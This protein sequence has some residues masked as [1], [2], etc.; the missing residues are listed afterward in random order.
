[1]S[2]LKT[3]PWLDGASLNEEVFEPAGQGHHQEAEEDYLNQQARD[4][5][6][7]RAELELEMRTSTFLAKS[8]EKE[9]T[10]RKR[11]KLKG[12]EEAMAEAVTCAS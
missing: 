10:L 8:A 4:A 11:L 9:R 7:R 6:K 1:M 2:F 3:C 12:A 5:T